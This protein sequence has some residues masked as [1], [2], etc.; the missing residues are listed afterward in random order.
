MKAPFTI[1]S[2]FTLAPSADSSLCGNTKGDVKAKISQLVRSWWWNKFTDKISPQ[3]SGN[4]NYKILNGKV[5]LAERGGCMF[6][7]KAIVAQSAGS[8][9]LIIQNNEVIMRSLFY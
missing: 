8:D 3:A 4:L 1:E 5:V 9:G 6:E 7:E 2:E